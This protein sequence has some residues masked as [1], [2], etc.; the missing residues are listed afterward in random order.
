MSVDEATIPPAPDHAPAT[1]PKVANHLVPWLVGGLAGLVIGA[2]AVGGAWALAGEE[3]PQQVETFELNGTMSLV[4]GPSQVSSMGESSCR[5]IGGY[6]DI[7]PGASVTVYDAAGA[8]VGTGSL[9][10]P[11]YDDSNFTTRVCRFPVSVAGVPKGSAIYQVEVTHRGKIS[12]R[13][14][15]AEAGKFAASLG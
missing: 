15:D 2:G 9:G 10:E 6:D 1:S 8:A 7:L 13:A 11:E 12:L 5:G 14:A 3:G 4:G